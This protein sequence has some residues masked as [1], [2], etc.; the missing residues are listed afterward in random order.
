M[1]AT[2]A[3]L[4]AGLRGSKRRYGQTAPQQDCL[5]HCLRERPPKVFWQKQVGSTSAAGRRWPHHPVT[6]CTIHTL[7]QPHHDPPRTPLRHSA[8]PSHHHPNATAH[9]P[10]HRHHPVD[11]DHHPCT[12]HPIT[13]CTPPPPGGTPPTTPRGHMARRAILPRTH[14]R[15]SARCDRVAAM[16]TPK[17]T[18]AQQLLTALDDELA[19]SAKH[20]G[21][22]LVW[23]VAEQGI[24]NGHPAVAL[25]DASRFDPDR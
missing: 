7:T 4:S 20:A 24:A 14:F 17:S 16:S 18:E 19:V 22:D 6:Q 2:F 10:R 5:R 23:S 9:H 1:T 15:R 12:H 25:V 21:R 3:V 13:Q 11:T 8:I